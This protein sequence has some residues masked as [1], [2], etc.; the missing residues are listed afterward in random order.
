M[1]SSYPNPRA[2]KLPLRDLVRGVRQHAGPAAAMISHALESLPGPLRNAVE[3]ITP[4]DPKGAGL[5]GPPDPMIV[6][7]AAA[8]M[9]GAD[10]SATQMATC[11]GFAISVLLAEARKPDLLVSETILAMCWHD[12][13]TQSYRA[14]ALL[15]AMV[16]REPFG[17]APGFMASGAGPDAGLPLRICIGAVLWL[18]TE[19]GDGATPE[20]ELVRISGWLGAGSLEACQKAWND[21]Q[22]L[23]EILLDV[24]ERI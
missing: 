6:A 19:P 7:N 18:L 23:N 17:V 9:Q 20:E 16:R 3:N 21:P 4:F 13:E 11:A 10:M 14:A 1:S 8:A 15:H 5:S 22:T 2:L 12:A 24:S